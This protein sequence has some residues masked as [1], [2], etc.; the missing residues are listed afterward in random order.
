MRYLTKN[1]VAVTVAAALVLAGGGMAASADEVNDAEY[2]AQQVADAVA[3]HPLAVDVEQATPRDEARALGASDSAAVVTLPESFSEPIEVEPGGL[4]EGSLKGLD[5]GLPE[6][7][8]TSVPATETESGALVSN[9]DGVQG[10]VEELK[11]GLR[12]STIIEGPTAPST[13]A[14]EL[15]E[16]VDITLN[17][18]G[19]A[20]LSRTTDQGPEGDQMT[21]GIGEI[22][23]AWAIDANGKPVETHYEVEGHSLVQVVEHANEDVTYPVVADPSFWWGWNL[24]ISNNA[25]SQITK[26]ILAGA[27]ATGV[28]TAVL[29]FV[30]G[31]GQVAN[32]ITALAGALLTFGAA[33]I[34][35]CNF[36]N[37]GIWV[38]QTWVAGVLPFTPRVFK[39][40]YFCVP[41]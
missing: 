32:G 35:M 21:A 29:R 40:G 1:V 30:P 41:E 13:F 14:Y 31:A 2:A 25:V 17:D 6:S 16:D 19:S 26:V 15:P 37:K 22:S 18:D 20:S 8:E 23:A 9:G 28:A 36:N 27:A 34:N 7:I 11:G 38:G 33:A 10:V 5:I 24:Y 4:W 12:V 39:G 3:A